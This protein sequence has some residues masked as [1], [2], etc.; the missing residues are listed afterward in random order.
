MLR[1]SPGFSILAIL[2]LTLGIGTNAP[3][4]ATPLPATTQVDYVRV[5]K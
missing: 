1:R 2:C 5:W 3:T 4:T